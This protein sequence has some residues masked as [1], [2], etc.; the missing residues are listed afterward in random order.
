M[1]M[2][3]NKTFSPTSTP[4]NRQSLLKDSINTRD[5]RYSLCPGLVGKKVAE[6]T[7]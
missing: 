1:K 5:N 7:T 6:L 4:K 3:C 2:N